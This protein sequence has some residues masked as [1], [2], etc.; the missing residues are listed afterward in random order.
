MLD[1]YERDRI[2]YSSDSL[3]FN[4]AVKVSKLSEMAGQKYAA[5]LLQVGKEKERDCNEV[6]PRLPP[7][8]R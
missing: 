5:G 8:G 2:D 1:Y 7:L 3:F 6:Y 4:I